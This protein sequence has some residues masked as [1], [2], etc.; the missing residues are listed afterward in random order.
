MPDT[1][2]ASKQSVA[3]AL[4]G[5]A[6]KLE[7]SFLPGETFVAAERGEEIQAAIWSTTTPASEL[8]VIAVPF[9]TRPPTEMV[10]PAAPGIEREYYQGFDEARKIGQLEVLAQTKHGPAITIFGKTVVGRMVVSGT[11]AGDSGDST[12]ILTVEWVGEG[13]NRLWIVRA[14]HELVPGTNSLDAVKSLRDALASII[15]S[16]E[17]LDHP[18]TLVTGD[19]LDDGPMLSSVP[20]PPGDDLEEAPPALID[21]AAA[22]NFPAP[23]WWDGDCDEH[24]FKAKD[25]LHR[26]SFRLNNGFR[27]VVPCGPLP[28]LEGDV[29]VQFPDAQGNNFRGHGEFEFQC[30]ELCMRFMEIVHGITAYPGNGSQVVPNFLTKSLAK[31]R[32][33]M[34][35]IQ[36]DA[37]PPAPVPG[38]ILSYGPVSTV[39]HTAVCVASNVDGQGNG[40]I[41]VMQQNVSLAG[42]ADLRVRNWRVLAVPS[43]TSFLHPTTGPQPPDPRIDST[44]V[45]FNETGHFIGGGFKALW[46]KP[47]HGVFLCG[48]PLTEEQAEGNLTVQYFENVR[49]EFRPGIQPRFGGV[50]R[51]FVE[52]PGSN[53]PAGVDPT[54]PGTRRFNSTGHSVG[55][56][57]LTLF[58]KY[59]LDVC[60][61][62]ITGEI[63]ENGVTVQYFE[64]VRME[65][66]QAT[67]ARFGAV[68]RRFLQLTGVIP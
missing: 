9:G 20:M 32:N 68:G 41:T 30:V 26:N 55:G 18:T 37:F 15:L 43:V 64:N 12:P 3:F 51:R 53:V 22:G 40:T 67:P 13:G 10:P 34:K 14:T 52:H 8:S 27:G 48:F 49:M 36:N 4:D 45:R 31:D 61:F 62:P 35:V 58:N 59:G 11:P 5:V 63:E 19:P 2:L 50:G 56:S 44:P 57:F 33:K 42:K 60:G 65:R 25:P 38:D 29:T 47:N 46:F 16:S 39:G 28:G 66:G 23:T 17:T 24:T 54:G 7:T 1:V 6:I 21:V